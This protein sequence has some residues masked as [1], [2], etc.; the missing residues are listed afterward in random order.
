[1][2]TA[3]EKKIFLPIFVSGNNNKSNNYQNLQAWEVFSEQSLR[4]NA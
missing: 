3:R 4:L 2:F 1:M